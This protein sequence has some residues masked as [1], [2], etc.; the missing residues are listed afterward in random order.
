ML[1][2]IVTD[3]G[4][5]ITEKDLAKPTSFGL[6]GIQERATLI[7]GEIEIDGAPHQGTSVTLRVPLTRPSKAP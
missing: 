6:R 3:D 4:I 7:G 2:M 1:A 5:G